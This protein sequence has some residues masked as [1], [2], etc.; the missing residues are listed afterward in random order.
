MI[1][2]KDQKRSW[3]GLSDQ[4]CLLED[5]RG[6]WGEK[7]VKLNLIQPILIPPKTIEAI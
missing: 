7:G 2:P 6:W 1:Y 5:G 3:I 4:V